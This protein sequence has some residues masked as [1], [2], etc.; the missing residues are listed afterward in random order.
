MEGEIMT[1]QQGYPQ[2]PQAAWQGGGYP[3]GGGANPATAIIAAILGI[4]I[5]GMLSYVNIDLLSEIPDGTPIPSEVTTTIILRFAVAA[6]ALIGA[7][8]VF[9]RKLAGAFLLLAAAVFTVGVILTEPA[10]FEPAALLL[11]DELPRV[12]STSAYGAF[13][14]AMFEFG[15]AQAILR[16][17]SLFAAPIL[18]IFSVLPPTLNH[19]KGSRATGYPQ[20]GYP[21][22]W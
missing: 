9:A 19:L 5:A 3:A 12:T 7:I 15:N 8:V 13:F 21:Q 20:Q 1:Y 4:A 22:S 10:I 17:L 6:I 14:E 16:A 18:L 2:Q 11:L